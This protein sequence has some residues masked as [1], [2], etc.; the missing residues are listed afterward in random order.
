[1]AT[2]KS[3]TTKMK[4]AATTADIGPDLNEATIKDLYRLLLDREP[5][6]YTAIQNILKLG[7]VQKVRDAILSSPEYRRKNPQIN[8]LNNL[9]LDLPKLSVDVDL[10]GDQYDELFGHIRERWTKLGNEKPHWSVLSSPIFQQELT[11]ELEDRFY[12]TGTTELAEV[13]ALLARAGRSLSD[14][15]RI[16]EYGCGLG[17]MTLQFGKHVSS[18]LGLDISTSHLALARD[19]AERLGSDNVSFETAELPDFGM[20]E[21]FDFWYSRIVLQHNPPPL[22]KAILTQALDMLSP[23]GIAIFQVP[24]HA[25]GYSFDLP[26]YLRSKDEGTDIEMHCLPQRDVF[27]VIGKAGCSA[28]EVREDR[29]VANPVYWTSN[30]FVVEKLNRRVT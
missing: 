9:P 7:S 8:A 3:K 12:Q 17:R 13:E 26:Q 21:N 16:V 2:R 11:P 10:S 18:V 25:V 19:M 29:S 22:I 1:M 5:E 23:G 4:S 30:T 6:S 14:I 28:V 27:E 24:T 20:T 15:S